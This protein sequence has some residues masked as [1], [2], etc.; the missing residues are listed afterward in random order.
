MRQFDIGLTRNDDV[1]LSLALVDPP[2]PKCIT[3]M[4]KKIQ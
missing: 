1:A 3:S 4:F 2:N